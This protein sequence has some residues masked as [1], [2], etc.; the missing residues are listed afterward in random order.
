MREEPTLL[1]KYL[2]SFCMFTVSK[3]LLMSRATVIVRAGGIIRLNPLAI[4]LLMLCST[5]IVEGLFE[6]VLCVVSDVWKKALFQ[7]FGNDWEK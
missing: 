5:V 6:A 1:C 7:S 2:V 4:V 3:A